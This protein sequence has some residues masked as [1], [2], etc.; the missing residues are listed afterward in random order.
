MPFII[1]IYNQSGEDCRPIRQFGSFNHRKVAER[2]LRSLGW[3]FIRED[4]VF[5]KEFHSSGMKLAEVVRTS[6]L[7]CEQL[8]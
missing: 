5:V 6:I 2:R 1:S 3:K 4:N 8:R 7:P